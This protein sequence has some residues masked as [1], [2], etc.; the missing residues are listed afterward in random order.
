MAR[1]LLERRLSELSDRMKRVRADLGV[2]EEQL[3]HFADEADD[4]R[5]RALVAETPL[6]EQVHREA[7]KHAEAMRRHREE[8]TAEI[9]DLER[10]QDDLLDR[11]TAD[12]S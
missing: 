12:R 1:S 8:L 7:Q 3:A 6:A 2:A 11:L 9:R 5:L 4:A 10:A